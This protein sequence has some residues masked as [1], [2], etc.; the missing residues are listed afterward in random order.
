MS[1]STHTSHLKAVWVVGG[2]GSS[3]LCV[4]WPSLEPFS[5]PM[6]VMQLLPDVG[7][8]LSCLLGSLPSCQS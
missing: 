8:S 2:A 6:E 1:S 4:Y 3:V 7:P 5:F